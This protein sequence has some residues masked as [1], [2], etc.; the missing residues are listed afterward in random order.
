MPTTRLSLLLL[1]ALA[2]CRFSSNAVTVITGD[3]SEERLRVLSSEH[4]IS[5]IE[6]TC[7]TEELLAARAI[8]FRDRNGNRRPD[9]GEVL[10]ELPAGLERPSSQVVWKHLPTPGTEADGAL[11]VRVE[12]E[13]S[14]RGTRVRSV[15]VKPALPPHP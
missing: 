8:V 11:F 13:G 12:L 15:R 3:E 6:L 14:E 1:A 10:H 2:G 5:R 4:E 7:R 9:E